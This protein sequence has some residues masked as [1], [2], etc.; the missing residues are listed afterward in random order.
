MKKAA[1]V[2]VLYTLG[3]GLAASVV[4]LVDPSMG[5]LPVAVFLGVPFGVAGGLHS[6]HIYL[7]TW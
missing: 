7:K 4:A 5:S 6:S 1:V 2:F 3:G